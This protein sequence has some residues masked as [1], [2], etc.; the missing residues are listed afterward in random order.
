VSSTARPWHSSYPASWA[1]R[2]TDVPTDL[3]TAY[4][5]TVAQH[6]AR[7]AVRYFDTAMTWE[8]ID[9][10]SDALAGYLKEAGIGRGDRLAVY[11]QNVPAYLV[12]V[13]A[14]WKRGAAVVPINPMNRE[15]E[16]E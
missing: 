3:L 10:Q 12:T 5:T 4:R 8:Q 9:R 16:E 15:R 2:P 14:T 1:H 6:G 13:L 11:L 7:P